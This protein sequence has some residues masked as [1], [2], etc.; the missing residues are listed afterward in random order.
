[1]PIDSLFDFAAVHVIG[2]QA[3]KIDLRIGFT[4]TD[5]DE[6]WTVWVNRGVLNARR[7][8]S[9]DPQLTVAGPKAALVGVALQPAAAS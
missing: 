3:A 6:T 7:G 9:P 4:F 1:M 2:D 5:L 8:A